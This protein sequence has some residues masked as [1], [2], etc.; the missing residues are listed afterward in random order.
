MMFFHLSIFS[1]RFILDT[2]AVDP[3]FTPDTHP[4]QGRISF[5]QPQHRLLGHFATLSH[6][7]FIL[8]HTVILTIIKEGNECRNKYLTV[9]KKAL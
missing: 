3:E 7:T 6:D 9:K 5:R 4:S 1:N 8:N 2:A